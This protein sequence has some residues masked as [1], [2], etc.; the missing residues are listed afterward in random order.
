MEDLRW[1]VCRRLHRKPL[2]LGYCGGERS[3]KGLPKSGTSL[4][5]G[6][7]EWYGRHWTRGGGRSKRRNDQCEVTWTDPDKDLLRA[8][9]GDP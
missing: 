6:F 3:F 9:T 2:Q 4:L 8:T 1:D 5:L 7:E